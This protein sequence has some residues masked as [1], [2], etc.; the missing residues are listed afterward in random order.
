MDKMSPRSMAHRT[1]KRATEQI[2][3]YHVSE[4]FLFFSSFPLCPFV[5]LWSLSFACHL[6]AH[7]LLSLIV[8]F[9]RGHALPLIQATNQLKCKHVYE[10]CTLFFCSLNII[11]E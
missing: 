5:P 7:N 8:L 2:L 11:S 3:N 1:K 10:N 9:L 4:Q 6:H